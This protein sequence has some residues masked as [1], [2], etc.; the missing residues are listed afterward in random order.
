MENVNDAIRDCNDKEFL[1]IGGDWNCTESR[2]DRNHVEPHP[3]SLTLLIQLLETHELHDV[4]RGLHDNQRQYT[5]THCKDNLLS[6]ARLVFI[7]LSIILMLL[8]I[9]LLALWVFLITHL[10]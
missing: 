10:L 6:M 5:W 4:W 9:A 2:L 7:V 8:K 3:A 1:F